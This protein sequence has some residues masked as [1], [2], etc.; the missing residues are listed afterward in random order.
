MEQWRLTVLVRNIDVC[1]EFL[2]QNFYMRNLKIREFFFFE[3]N[4]LGTCKC[5]SHMM[6][7][8][9]GDKSSFPADV[10]LT[11]LART[12][13]CSKVCPVKVLESIVTSFDARN[14]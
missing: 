11:R 8:T 10:R 13:Q 14:W 6:F 3:E 1:A 4:N 5:F 7:F 9:L 12:A 2:N